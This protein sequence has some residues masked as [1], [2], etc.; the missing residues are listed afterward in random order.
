MLKQ[1]RLKFSGVA[2]MISKTNDRNN[3]NDTW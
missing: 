1:K 3:I 2:G